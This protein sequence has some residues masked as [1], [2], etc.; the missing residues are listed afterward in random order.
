[1]IDRDVPPG[2]IKR[3]TRVLFEEIPKMENPAPA[4]LVKL[5]YK[6]ADFYYDQVTRKEAYCKKGCSWCCRVPVDVSAIEAQLIGEYIGIEP[7][8][9]TADRQWYRMP[10]KTKCP[11][12]KNDCCSIYPVRPFNCRVFASAD[13]PKN[14]VDGSTKHNIFNYQSNNGLN[15]MRDFLDGVSKENYTGIAPVADIREWWGEN[16]IHLSK[17]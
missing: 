9:L 11:F 14:C 10:D 13:D 3:M 2:V 15:Y 17:A 12:L 5:I 7:K 8:N 6:T 1:M 16:L 4:D